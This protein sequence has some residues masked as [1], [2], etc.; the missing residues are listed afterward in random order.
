MGILPLRTPRH[1]EFL[2]ERVSGV[3]IPEQVRRRMETAD[4][5]VAEGAA[6]AA[7]MLALARQN[8]A[9]ACLM[10][11]FNHYEVLDQILTSQT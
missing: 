1:A 4:D 10:P 2:H 11:P 9:G 8:F 3:I 5:P 7:E 6:Q